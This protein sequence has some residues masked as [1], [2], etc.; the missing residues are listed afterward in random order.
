MS[1][2]PA[3]TAGLILLAD[4]LARCP[5]SALAT[6]DRRID[7]HTAVIVCASL[8]HVAYLRAALLAHGIDLEALHLE[9]SEH[10]KALDS[11]H[12]TNKIISYLEDQQATELEPLRKFFQYLGLEDRTEF[13]HT[14]KL[15]IMLEQRS[16]HLV[17]P[18]AK[19]DPDDNLHVREFHTRAMSEKNPKW[20]VPPNTL[21]AAA[22]AFLGSSA[23]VAVRDWASAD[24]EKRHRARAAVPGATAH[25]PEPER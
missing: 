25:E 1:V 21:E 2:L 19:E 14:R 6:M 22:Q 8:V 11:L 24:R 12:D 20:H 10:G 17:P 9:K 13:E 7:L 23:F 15:I 18:D 16:F 4:S 5:W 3:S